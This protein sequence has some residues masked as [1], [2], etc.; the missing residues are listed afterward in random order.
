MTDTPPRGRPRPPM[1][2]SAT[3][4]PD[5]GTPQSVA[6]GSGQPSS[7]APA[8][9][10]SGSGAPAAGPS[11]SNT[12]GSGP[13]MSGEVRPPGD[14]APTT[15][16]PAAP[17]RPAAEASS[18]GPPN[19]GARPAGQGP[20]PLWRSLLF[21]LVPTL[22][23]LL[24]VA[25]FFFA[26]SGRSGPVNLSAVETAGTSLSVQIPNAE[27]TLEPSADDQVHVSMTGTFFGNEPTLTVRTEDGVTEV[28]GGCK[29]QLFARCAV[30]VAV[31]LPP[32]LPVTVQAQNGR[33]AASGLTGQVTLETTNGA[34][35]T[36][37]TV[38]QVDART[39]NGDIRVTD[40]AS[41]TVQATTT[42]GSVEL[43]FTDAP[44]V[45]DAG[46]TNGSVIVRVPVSGV[47]YLVTTQT[48]NGS[49]NSGTVP[50]DS[51]SRRTITAQTTNGGITIEATR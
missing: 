30:D 51:T 21:I 36:D 26:L 17:A 38:G 48:T 33:I 37:G 35:E 31:Q 15:G 46:S 40:A 22:G 44:D 29:A 11:S 20:P 9:E 14:G 49:V 27:L 3:G 23:V 2:R 42:N 39:T 43:T 45:V 32:D 7:E 6:P 47:S 28:R 1:V 4:P 10:S 50:S 18:A 5:T 24:L 25:A 8:F 34:I 19:G 16:R 13:P 12:V 41:K